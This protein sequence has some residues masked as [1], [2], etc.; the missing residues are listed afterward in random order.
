MAHYTE[1]P[2]SKQQIKQ[3]KS[4]KLH[5][6]FLPDGETRAAL[7]MSLAWHLENVIKGSHLVVLAD[8]P[9]VQSSSNGDLGVGWRYLYS[10]DVEV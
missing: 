10:E 4:A 1:R 3:F 8:E 6:Y 7:S 9:P 2:F 5:H